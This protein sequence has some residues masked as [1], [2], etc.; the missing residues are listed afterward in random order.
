M[1]IDVRTLEGQRMT[2]KHATLPLGSALRIAPTFAATATAD[3]ISVETTISAAYSADAGRYRITAAAHRAVGTT[4]EITPT[5]LRQVRLGELMSAAV[6]HCVAVE[7]EGKQ[8]T[9]R[10]LLDT[11]GRLLPQWMAQ[12]AATAGPTA[13][14]L[15]LVELVYGVAALAALAPTRA[16]ATEFGIPERTASHC[17]TK[18]RKAG[19]LDGITYAVGRR[20]DGPSRTN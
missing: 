20:P 8:R 7:F 5:V 4:M 6:P 14:T 3:D 10:D 17:V 18:S 2:W 11:D 19:L 15:E 13:N 16:V 9:L 12:A 1:K